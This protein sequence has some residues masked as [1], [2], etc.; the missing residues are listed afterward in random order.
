MQTGRLALS[1]GDFHSAVRWLGRASRLLPADV[2][3]AHLLASAQSRLEPDTAIALLRKLVADAPGYREAHVALAAL[4][5]RCCNAPAAAQALDRVLRNFAV[6]RDE[7]FHALATRIAAQLGHAGWVGVTGEGQLTGNAAALSLAFDEA[8]PF[9]N[10]ALSGWHSLPRNWRKAFLL[11]A[12][13]PVG[14]ILGDR[15]DLPAIRHVEGVVGFDPGQF[16]HGWALAPS[17]PDTPMVIDIFGPRG[18]NPLASITANEAV[19]AAGH[20]KGAQHARGF[21][22]PLAALHMPGTLHIRARQGAELSG[23]PICIGAEAKAARRAL[24]ALRDRWRP[25]PVMLAGLL[26]QAPRNIPPRP[27]LDIIIVTAGDDDPGTLQMAHAELPAQTRIISIGNDRPGRMASSPAPRSIAAAMNASLRQAGTRD[28]LIL[29][30]RIRLPPGALSCLI[31]AAYAA[32]DIGTVTPMTNAAG[33]TGL[34]AG[35]EQSGMPFEAV[36]ASNDA[37]QSANAATRVDLPACTG[38]CILIRHDCLLETGYFRED[39]FPQGGGAAEDFARRAAILGWRHVAACD[40]LAADDNAAGSQAVHVSLARPS[41]DMLERLHP[42]YA[43]LMAGFSSLDPLRAARTAYDAKR[44]EEGRRGAAVVLVTHDQGGGVERHV[45]ERVATIRALG[46]RAIVLRPRAGFAISDGMDDTHPNLLFAGVDALAAFLAADQPCAVELHHIAEH[47]AGIERLAGTLRVA[48]DYILHDYAAICPR[49]TFCAA[50][51]YCGAPQDSRICDDCIA[52]HGAQIPFS[53]PVAAWREKHAML[54]GAARRVVAPSRDAGERLKRFFGKIEPAVTHW[55]DDTTWPPAVV[56]AGASAMNVAVV[57][58]IGV[59]KGY[60]VLLACAR[61]AAQRALPLRFTVVGHTIDDRRLLDTGR[62]FITGPFAEGEAL[63]LLREESPTCGFL[64]SIWPETWCY[65]LSAL[66]QAG[67][68][69]MAFDLGA[70]AERIR[71]RGGG[72][73]MPP[74]SLPGVLNDRFLALPGLQESDARN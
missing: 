34:G 10:S 41:S 58:G 37:V 16:L 2:V 64:P 43:A 15:I 20:H 28:V 70:Q 1:A 63:M 56:K 61:D 22:L 29:H 4:Y 27:P 25:A 59:E 72:T 36:L 45:S 14:R 46:L 11:R 17:D 71:A 66:W 42:G 55:E 67:L 52:D 49:V 60:F 3:V 62:V 50:N 44:W 38:A 40:A 5:S 9:L 39:A 54:L 69:V 31:D 21:H 48:F 8:S 23:S 13:S 51:T 19:S 73:L 12:Q 53:G 65:A 35:G 32:P 24:R 18:S 74:G 26:A 6:P 57:G 33:I 7:S 47:E 30:S 68:H